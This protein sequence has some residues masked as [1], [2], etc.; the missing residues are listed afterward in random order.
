[1]TVFREA[2]NDDEYINASNGDAPRF[3]DQLLRHQ[4]AARGHSGG[5][6]S[7]RSEDEAIAEVEVD[8]E[9]IDPEV[10]EGDVAKLVAD[11]IKSQRPE[12]IEQFG[13][14]AAWEGMLPPPEV[15]SRYPTEVQERWMRWNDG[16]LPGEPERQDRLVDAQIDQAKTGQAM[17]MLLVF[18]AVVLA[19]VFGLRGDIL[20]AIGFI[21]AP[22]LAYAG[23]LILK[24]NS[25]SSQ[26][27][28]D[29]GPKR[30]I[31]KRS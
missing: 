17:S 13:A 25:K 16:F 3:G 21:S 5:A 4:P 2:G 28:S 15:F 12:V 11:V 23:S 1:M 18:V 26:H 6:A 7:G 10:I 31:V 8:S 24:L 29:D 9:A 30:D 22:L 27:H 14:L 19:T 20:L